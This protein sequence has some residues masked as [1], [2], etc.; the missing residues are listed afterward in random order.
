MSRLSLALLLPLTACAMMQRAPQLERGVPIATYRCADQSFVVRFPSG[1]AEL[2][3]A[4]GS[5]LTL[6]QQPSG[7]GFR[8]GDARHELRGKGDEATWTVGRKMPVT[9]RAEAAPGA[10]PRN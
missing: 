5:T 7:S 3:F 6:S 8:Y 9:C 1:H 4:D 2:S 10:A